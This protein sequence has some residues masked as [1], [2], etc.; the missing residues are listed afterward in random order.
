MQPDY[1][2]TAVFL[3]VAVRELCGFNSPPRTKVLDFGCGP[4][5]LLN[6]L[7][8]DG[9]D[10]YGCDITAHWS[11]DLLA[12]QE[13]LGV[14]SLTP[15]RLPFAKNTFDIVISTSVLEHVRNKEECFREIHR[16]LRPNGYSLHIYP[17]K[18]Y[19]PYDPHTYVPLSNYFG[20]SCPRWW[21]GLWAI[22]GTG[23]KKQ[24]NQSWR[25]F[26]ESNYKYYREELFYWSNRQYRKL[27][28][29]IFGNCSWPM[30]FYINN[31]PGGFAGTFRKLPFKKF[32]GW[33]LKE[34]RMSFLVQQ[35]RID[36]LPNPNN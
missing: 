11:K 29:R 9:F 25:K 31:A 30:Q 36:K 10:A 20:R 16:V 1:K 18:W 34:C 32:S 4:G 12:V 26:F 23:T 28:L 5:N 33:L 2:K 24:R 27:S 22:L 17:G 13:R 35:K 3:E 14:I 6:L 8:R 21:F 7:L 19:L 15:Y